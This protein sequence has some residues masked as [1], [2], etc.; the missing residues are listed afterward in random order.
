MTK[1]ETGGRYNLVKEVVKNIRRAMS[2]MGKAKFI[3][4]KNLRLWQ[5]CTARYGINVY[6]MAYPHE[7][8]LAILN[9]IAQELILRDLV[10]LVQGVDRMSQDDYRVLTE[11]VVDQ[12][13][14]SKISFHVP[15]SALSID[16]K[17]QDELLVANFDAKIK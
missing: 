11:D 7:I 6:T 12:E 14:S 3:I 1:R 17:S 15:N 9:S 4:L 2:S 16:G 5:S 8:W 10:F 13:D